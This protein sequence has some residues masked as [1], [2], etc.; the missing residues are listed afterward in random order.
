MDKRSFELM[1]ACS[2]NQDRIS[3][4]SLAQHSMEIGDHQT[5]YWA[6]RKA[7]ELSGSADDIR[8]H[9]SY[10]YDLAATCAYYVGFHKESLEFY[11]HAWRMNPKDERLILNIKLVRSHLNDYTIYILWPTI[12]PDVYK[13]RVS[14]WFQNCTC[15]E[16]IRLIVAVNTPKQRQKLDESNVLVLGSDRLGVAYASYKLAQACDG[17]PGDIIILASDDFHPPVGWDQW[18]YENMREF[19]GCILVNDADNPPRTHRERVVTIPIMDFG[20]LQMLNRIIYHPSYHHL[21]SDNELYDNLSEMKLLK[22]LQ[23]PDQPV[24]EHRHWYH[25]ARQKDKADEFV[26]EHMEQDRQNYLRRSSFSLSEKLKVKEE[27]N[28]NS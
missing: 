19:H 14:E 11:T 6:A 22:N 10:P 3:L 26:H 5:G 17:L 7:I 23:K 9:G 13:E 21:Y 15:D 27:T 25:G 24:F 18:I 16:R 4:L 1:G 12:R 28:A 2:E 8:Q 20:C